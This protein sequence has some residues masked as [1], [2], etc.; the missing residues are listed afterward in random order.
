MDH[1][2]EDGRTLYGEEDNKEN[3]ARYYEKLYMMPTT[4][5]HPYHEYVLNMIKLYGEDQS[6]DHNEYNREP[7]M[8]EV[9]KAICKKKEG[10]ATTD[11]KYELIKRGGED[12]SEAILLWVQDCW[13]TEAVPNQWKEGLISNIW[14]NKGDREVMANQRGI[15]VSSAIGMITEDVVHTRIQKLVKFTQS[16][17]EGRKENSTHDAPFLS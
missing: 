16:Q 8:E 10:K 15:N 9:K 14:K 4:H 5:H 12:M 11:L 13:Q 7:T 3:V 2:N 6:H 1:K 17:A